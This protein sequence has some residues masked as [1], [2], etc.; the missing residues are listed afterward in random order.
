MTKR[1][2]SLAVEGGGQVVVHRAE[3]VDV[4]VGRQQGA[5]L[6]AHR[7]LELDPGGAEDAV[8]VLGEAVQQVDGL[9]DLPGDGA[10]QAAG[11]EVEVAAVE[12]GEG[13]GL[14]DDQRHQHDQQAARQQAAGQHALHRAGEQAHEPGFST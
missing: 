13:H 2:P 12:E 5:G 4:G 8:P 1:R 3:L 14:Q 6:Q 10:G 7:H 9:G 11:H